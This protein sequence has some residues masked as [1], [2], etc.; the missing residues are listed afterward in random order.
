MTYRG[1]RSSPGASVT[2]RAEMPV[3]VSLVDVPHRLDDRPDYRAGRCASPPG[4]AIRRRP[5]TPAARPRPRPRR[6]YENTEDEMHRA[7]EVAK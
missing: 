7:G 5:T 1:D 6:A 2:L 3:I 4:G